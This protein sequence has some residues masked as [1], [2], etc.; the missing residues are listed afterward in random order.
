MFLR[1]V[2]RGSFTGAASQLGLTLS[3][4]SRKI[5]LLEDDL[6]VQLLHRTTRRVS[7]TEAG[8]DFYE[9]CLR[10]EGILQEAER[11][12]RALKTEP[13]GTLRIL[14]PYAIGLIELEPLLAE[15]RS[16]YPKVQLVLIYN[17]SPLDLIEHGIDVALR[18][19]PLPESGYVAR[20]LGWS[21]AKL[22]ASP[23]YLDRAGR[24][25][26]PLDLTRHDILFVGREIP[27]LTLQLSSSA[28]EAVEIPVKPVLITN[29]SVT[30]LRQAVSGG[31]IALVSTHI[32][33]GRLSND[34]LEIVLPDWHRTHDL[35]LNAL[36]ARRATL[37][38]KVRVFID[39]L[40]E[41][42]AAWQ[43]IS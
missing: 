25:L 16:R 36:Y 19:G 38:H 18:T 30:V 35:E 4:T 17:N 13:E 5:K 29:E 37:D 7:V 11:S 14:V 15:F 20:P 39:F 42:F 24:P 10:A 21:R 40:G 43:V 28:G 2:E 22:A 26:S 6:G 12:V 23:G 34:E 33:S 41:V 8:H 3:R 31:G 9:R 1:V 32:M 27:G